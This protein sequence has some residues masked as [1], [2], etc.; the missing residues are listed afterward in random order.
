M[1]SDVKPSKRFL[2]DQLSRGN[3]IFKFLKKNISMKKGKMLD[4]G[5]SS[6]L[7]LMPFLKDGWKA[8]GYDPEKFYVE[9]GKSKYNLPIEVK[10]CE[11]MKLKRK[12]FDLILI[13]G[14]LEHCYD[15]NKILKI[16]AKASK[17]NSI[18][19][20]EGRGY[21]RSTSKHY[22]NHNH[23]RYFTLNSFELMMI[24]HGWKPIL[25]T[26][27]P[28]SG[29]TREGTNWVIGTFQGVNKN[30]KKK[31]N[32]LIKNGKNESYETMKHYFLFYDVINKD[33]NP[34]LDYISKGVYKKK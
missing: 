20:L 29:P 10:R 3:K 1:Y 18:L 6:G 19:V 15:P 26:L 4:V 33:I 5:C 27:Y 8:E 34:N 31:L 22:F 28:I 30:I 14:S 11:D 17:K 9:Y 32:Y 25:S 21:P 7:M 24:K 12:S 13:A 23:H 16:C 2:K